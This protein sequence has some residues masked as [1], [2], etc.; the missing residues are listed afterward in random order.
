MIQS[1]IQ[2]IIRVQVQDETIQ[3]QHMI[4]QT[5]RVRQD[6]TKAGDHHGQKAKHKN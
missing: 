5:K 3:V 4:Q 6:M 1:T 2:N